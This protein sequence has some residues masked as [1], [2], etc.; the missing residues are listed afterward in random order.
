MQWSEMSDGLDRYVGEWIAQ[1]DPSKSLKLDISDDDLAEAIA[2]AEKDIIASIRQLEL[3]STPLHAP[4][5]TKFL[6]E[7]ITH[8]N[9]SYHAMEE[10]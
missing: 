2:D 8:G 3:G 7:K 1:S 9:L 10:I 5:S 4:V 6:R